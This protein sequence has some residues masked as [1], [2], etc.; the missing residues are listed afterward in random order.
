MPKVKTGNDWL[1]IA[2]Q[3]I[4]A[5]DARLL[6]QQVTGFAHTDLIC[7]PDAPLSEATVKTLENLLQRRAA[8]EPLAYLIGETSFRGRPFKVTPAVL[9]PRPETE[10]LVDV[11][12]A[13]LHALQRS[14][15]PPPEREVGSRSEGAVP[16]ESREKAYN[17]EA[18]KLRILDM[19]T[20]SGVIAISLALEFPTAQVTACDISPAALAI[21]EENAERLRAR[22]RF[23]A[24]DWFSALAGERFHLI[25][26]NPPYIAAADPHL[27]GDGLR[28]EP[29]LA[30][31]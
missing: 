7:R 14:A 26:A 30:L 31:T 11:A 13:K 16:K 18:D 24:S 3:Q 29:R 28:F 21:A 9:T 6:L 20:G 22:A 15:P 2:R 10:E 27:A 5:L 17:D 25:V 8:G 1:K 19:G 4:D 12:L 23:L